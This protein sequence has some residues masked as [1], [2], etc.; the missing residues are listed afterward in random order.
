MFEQSILPDSTAAQNKSALAASFSAQLLAAGV[1]VVV[2]LLTHEVL[3]AFRV[4]AVPL[5]FTRFEPAAPVVG[6]AAPEP[7]SNTL[8]SPFSRRRVWNP[9]PRALHPTPPD[10]IPVVTE[11]DLPIDM[12]PVAST[13]VTRPRNELPI[14]IDRIKPPEPPV[15]QVEKPPAA[16]VLVTSEMQAAKILRKVI[17]LYPPLAKAARV[18]GTV[19]LI[20]A[21]AKDG[22]I[23]QLR[24][25]GGHPILAQ[26]ALDAVRQW[27]YRPTILNGEP[28][29]VI[30]PIDVTFTLQ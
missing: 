18:Q 16:P 28:V 4:P 12:G 25:I 30:A 26:A 17:P 10:G 20:G 22:T 1:L 11:L 2:P 23:Q 3:P 27:L 29:E 5:H 6:R 15:T 9:E 14:P 8:P 19:R 13:P 7:V 24:L 21:I